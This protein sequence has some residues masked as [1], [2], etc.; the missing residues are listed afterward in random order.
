MRGPM[1]R[2][3]GVFGLSLSLLACAG[4]REAYVSVPSVEGQAENPGQANVISL[5]GLTLVICPHNILVT[6]DGI[7]LTFPLPPAK[8]GGKVSE[9]EFLIH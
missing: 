9:D 1:R 7:L 8:I 3:L 2:A 4:V 5:E 6:R